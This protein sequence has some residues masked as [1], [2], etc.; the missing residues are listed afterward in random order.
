[1]IQDKSK[2]YT[3][4]KCYVDFLLK[5]S[6][7]RRVECYGIEKI[8]QNS[9]IIYAANHTNP[10]IDALAVLAIDNNHKVFV[11]RADIFKNP[12]ILKFLTFLKMLPI[13]RKRDGIENLSKNEE[14]NDIVINALRDKVPFCIMPEGT[15]RQ[16]HGL[17]PLVKGIFRIALQANDTFGQTMPVYIVPVGISYGHF[18]RP[19]GS[20]MLVQIGDSINVTQFVKDNSDANIALQ[21]NGLRNKLSEQ[22]KKVILDIPNEQNYEGIMQLVQLQG[23]K[24]KSLI[25]RF[26][27]AKENIKNI[28]NDLISSPEKTQQ[29]LDKAKEFY[30]KRHELNIGMNSILKK[31]L[32]LSMLGN[33]FWLLIG[34]PYFVFC[35]AVTSP[36]TLLSQRL[37]SKFEDKAFHN[38]VRFLITL[39]LLP[40]LL[41]LFSII[42][43]AVFGWKWGVV[44]ILL[45][46]PSFF[47]LHEYLRLIRLFISD[48][49]FLRYKNNLFNIIKNY[50]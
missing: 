21:I 47:F 41:L 49:K 24:D 29:L 18:L 1:V 19:A 38:T 4:L 11:A 48:I 33:L 8:P 42:V 2:K 16:K 37:C 6:A 28:E 20:S 31:N 30:T 22:M 45:F 14:I 5:K 43:F 39:A 9:A 13:N 12:V 46:I 40:L 32:L 50:L 26:L 10:L 44:F 35:A 25:N 17:L 15:H 23:K 3:A 7:F 27:T 36:I 34:L